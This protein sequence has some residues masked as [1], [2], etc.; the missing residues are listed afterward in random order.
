MLLTNSHKIQANE[1]VLADRL[2]KQNIPVRLIKQLG[3]GPCYLKMKNLKTKV[4][5]VSRRED[6]NYNLRVSISG[7]VRDGEIVAGS[8]DYNLDLVGWCVV[9]VGEPEEGVA[10]VYANQKM[11]EGLEN[12]IEWT[13]TRKGDRPNI[14][15]EGCTS[16]FL[17]PSLETKKAYVKDANGNKIPAGVDKQG[18]P[19]F[20]MEEYQSFSFVDSYF[21]GELKGTGMS[22]GFEMSLDDMKEKAAAW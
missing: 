13:A 20:Q 16:A 21:D 3:N 1:Q 5:N 11:V 22:E 17:I 7:C 8:S 4:F 10:R 19:Q 18:K 2:A 9:H 14:W 6:G 15:F 12:F